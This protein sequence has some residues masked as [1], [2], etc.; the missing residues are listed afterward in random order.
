M[1]K[2][3][4]YNGVIQE[5][6]LISQAEYNE[7]KFVEKQIEEDKKLKHLMTPRLSYI[8][9]EHKKGKIFTD[10]SP[11]FKAFTN[12]GDIVLSHGTFKC[13]IELV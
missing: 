1:Y 6:E 13:K 8:K 5:L 3:T 4:Y 2:V 11:I 10:E 7:M 12:G 9:A